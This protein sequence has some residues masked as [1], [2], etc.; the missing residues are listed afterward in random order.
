MFNLSTVSRITTSAD[1]PQT[2]F[3]AAK[4]FVLFKTLKK[5]AIAVF[6]LIAFAMGH[7]PAAHGQTMPEGTVG[8]WALGAVSYS[9]ASY[10][11]DPVSA[12]KESAK[13]HMHTD[14][15]KMV[16]TAN[17]VPIYD[18]WYINSV[19]GGALFP[20]GQTFL[21]CQS[22]YAAVWPGICVRKSEPPRPVYCS[23]NSYAPTV[24]NPVVVTTG[25]K[26]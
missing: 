6:V 3:P 4:P 24:G 12:C 22:G 2:D 7:S 23:N 18:C 16:P 1:L 25:V 11:S 9:I 8:W 21:A 13:N 26:Y 19:V 15:V 14:L 17:S 10:W 20:Y 5:W